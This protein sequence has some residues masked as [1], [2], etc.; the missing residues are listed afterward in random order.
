MGFL[1]RAGLVHSKDVP[2][3]PI[4]TL[5]LTGG[6]WIFAEG[7]LGRHTPPPDLASGKPD[8]RLQRSIQYAAAFRFDH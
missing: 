7:A 3:R 1:F 6:E 8:D 4:P 2:A 5:F